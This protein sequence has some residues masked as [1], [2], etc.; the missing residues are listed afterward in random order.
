[1]SLTNVNGSPVYKISL[2]MKC[3]NLLK[4][5][6]LQRRDDVSRGISGHKRTCEQQ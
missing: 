2:Y 5:T 1:M 4:S 3:D 6:G